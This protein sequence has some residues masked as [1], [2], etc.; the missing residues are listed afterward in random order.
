MKKIAIFFT[1]TF[2]IISLASV[3][4][5]SM[6]RAKG[7]ATIHKNFIDIARAKALDE[8]QRNAVEKAVGVM[9]T[10]ATCV[11]NYQ[12]KMDRILSES[13]GYIN[14]YKIIAEG[15]TGS[16]YE[17]EIEAQISEGKLR[18]KMS[19][20]NLIME[21][22]S[23]PRIML[24]FT[25]T[26]ANNAVAEA[27]MTKYFISE[28]FRLVD[29]RTIKKNKDNERLQRVSD[30]KK[31]SGIA[32]KYGAEIII[33]CTMEAV[34]NPFKIENIE[35]NHNKVIISGKIING[36]T[37]SI[38][39]TGS[40]QKAI[41][42]M[43]GDFKALTDEVSAKLSRNLVDSILEYWSAELT[44][45]T[46][47][48]LVIS[49]LNSYADLNKFKVLLAEEVKGYKAVHQRFYSHGKAEFDLD[50]KGGSDAVAHDI[51]NIKIKNKKIKVLEI[52]PNRVEA[53]FVQ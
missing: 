37:G 12:V 27:A 40:E 52:S 1:L 46:I 19:A 28:G 35:M 47:V 6:T 31:I 44:N 53:V 5:D 29:S 38:I 24:V 41:P 49:G 13:K 26:T 8:A 20:V 10:S 7:M 4:A 51:E 21:R 45:S 25:G 48:K 18:D 16:N 30:Q 42:G 15:K 32:H 17:V 23:K 14:S 39:T 33:M 22:K 50:I 36:D 9:I 34:S 3:Y 43:K 2:F 11:E